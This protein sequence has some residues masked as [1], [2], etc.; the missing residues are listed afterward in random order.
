MK[1]SLHAQKTCTKKPDVSLFNKHTHDN[2]EI[3]CFLSGDA[4][5]F[6]EGTI[7]DLKP[8]DILIIKKSD[9]HCL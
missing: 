3:F 8:N 5:Y 9:I 4:K 1:D 6:I 2:Y 7:Y